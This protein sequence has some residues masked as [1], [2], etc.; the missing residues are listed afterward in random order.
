MPVWQECYSRDGCNI[1]V[2]CL[3][4]IVQMLQKTTPCECV[5]KSSSTTKMIH[6]VYMKS[7][8]ISFP[9]SQF[10]TIWQL[11]Q[12]NHF[13]A[14]A[15]LTV[16]SAHET[17]YLTPSGSRPV[18]M[19]VGSRLDQDHIAGPRSCSKT[20]T[21]LGTCTHQGSTKGTSKQA[22]R[23]TQAKGTCIYRVP[24]KVTDN[25]SLTYPMKGNIRAITCKVF[26]FLS[27]TL[28]SHSWNKINQRNRKC[29]SLAFVLLVIVFT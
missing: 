22:Y 12:A 29:R 8:H 6:L 1:C 5:R 3:V 9:S 14:K 18:Q 4:H 16:K 10:S 2:I 19:Y 28:S 27:V 24:N 11:Y 20:Q 23:V 21:Q 15:Q 7:Y 25:Q 26:Y 17:Y 13:L